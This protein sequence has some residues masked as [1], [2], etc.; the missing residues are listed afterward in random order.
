M[1]FK[2]PKD[3]TFGIAESDLQ[4][5]GSTHPQQYENAQ[6]TMW[7]VFARKKKI[8]EPNAGSF[9]YLKYQEDAEL[10]KRLGVKAYRTSVSMS[11]TI[12]SDGRVN[13]KAIRWY[14]QYFKLLKSSGIKLH[15][16]LYHWEA[17]ARFAKNGILDKN[18]SAYFLRHVKICLENFSDL[19]DYFIP[20]NE[21]WPICYLGYFK[22]IHA[23]GKTGLANFF[24]AY[25]Q[26]IK[27]QSQIIQLI[28]VKAKKRAGIVNI[29]FPSYTQTEHASDP[30]YIEARH[31]ADSLTNLIYTDPLY[32]G[33]IDEIVEQKYKKYFPKN[34]QSILN[35]A[36]QG[37]LIDYYG[38]NYYNSQYIKPAKNDF[39]FDWY[40]PKEALKNSL[41]WPV[42]LPPHYPNG[43]TDALVNYSQRYSPV[44]LKQIMI[45]ENGVPGEDKFRIFFIQ[46][47]LAQIQA[48]IAKGALVKGYFHWTLL[49]NYEW[50]EGFKSKSA[51]GLVAVNRK[52][53][54]RLPKPSF[55]WYKRT[56]K[57]S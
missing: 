34:Y 38:V 50:T 51:F 4:T 56:I 12:D 55:F 19:A 47:H 49:D 30:K 46:K 10:I 36:C 26:M 6:A 31:W 20:I 25:F 16:C 33:S 39:G 22:G 45:T 54:Q 41:G 48:A 8:D 21:F 43:L 11:R 2:L 17:P 24:Q 57:N 27:L 7:D 18:F 23:P 52:T 32:F 40:T 3:F 29:H 5:V 28:K 15:L 53:G 42:S 44:G 35:H 37:K 9:K 1:L 14:R 13:K